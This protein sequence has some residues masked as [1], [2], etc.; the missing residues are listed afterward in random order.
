MS[1]SFQPRFFLILGYI[2]YCFR[3][4]GQ[5]TSVIQTIIFPQSIRSM[6]ND[7]NGLIF[8]E[9]SVGLFQFDGEK[10]RLIDP[11]YKKG[12]LVFRNGKLTNQQ[13]YLNAKIGFV[14]DG[15]KNLIWLPFL[16]KQSSN[17]IYHA[18]G[19]NGRQFL[20][21]GNNIYEVSIKNQFKINLKGIS[22]RNI[23]WIDSNL[24]VNTYDGIFKNGVQILPNI[25]F[26]DAILYDKLYSSVYFSFNSSILQLNLND[27]SYSIKDYSYDIGNDNY[28]SKIIK[29]QDKLFVGTRK[30]LAQ[31]NPFSQVSKDLDVNDITIIDN[32]MYISTRRGTYQFDGKKIKKCEFFPDVNTNLVTKI[33]L[34]F[35]VLTSDGL[36]KYDTKFKSLEKIILNDK[37]PSLECNAIQKDNNGFYWVSTTSGL[38]RFR[39]LNEQKEV[40]FPEIEFNKR[41]NYN[42]EGI[43]YFGS[44]NGIYSFDPLDFPDLKINYFSFLANLKGLLLILM[45]LVISILIF[46]VYKRKPIFK[47]P[48][49]STLVNSLDY[50]E[51]DKVLLDLGT[52]IL[53]NLHSV[54]VE[55]LIDYSGMNKRIFYKY[56]EQNYNVLPSNIINTI[57]LLKAKS[58]KRGN[59]GLPMETIARHVGYSLS[60]LYLVLKEEDNEIQ[61]ELSILYNLKY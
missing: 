13:S 28:I 12:T 39:N 15:E 41:S 18:K 29:F 11:E 25:P 35:W 34:F 43:F 23:S 19:K 1:N 48:A 22:T 52:F 20:G 46:I 38:Y 59:P 51:K 58:L 24:Y 31:L 61:P 6:A 10:S 36:F 49:D 17:V 3:L 32:V 14:G 2:S 30:G 42:H 16:P 50:R 55:D 56:I 47:L 33:G 7:Q 53:N 27:Q 44:L 9:T 45:L 4:T 21:V 8:I 37:L 5:D 26:A 40:Y 60:H 54:T 57:K